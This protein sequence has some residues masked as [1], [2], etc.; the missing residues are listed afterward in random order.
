M[1]LNYRACKVLPSVSTTLPEALNAATLEMYTPKTHCLVFKLKNPSS[2]SHALHVS[3]KVTATGVISGQV[4][5]F[6]VFE[7]F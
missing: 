1:F 4:I 2:L 3:D 7:R 5:V 6:L